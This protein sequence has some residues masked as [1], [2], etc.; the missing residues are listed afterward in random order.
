M[1]MQ[2]SSLS[3]YPAFC[4]IYFARER[5]TAKPTTM[6]FN[7]L[8]NAKE[9]GNED[10]SSS[11]VH[12]FLSS[13]SHLDRVCVCSMYWALRSSYEKVAYACTPAAFGRRASATPMRLSRVTSVCSCAS[14]QFYTQPEKGRDEQCARVQ[15]CQMEAVAKSGSVIDRFKGAA[16][17]LNSPRCPPAA[18]EAPGSGARR[19]YHG[20]LCALRLAVWLKERSKGK[21]D[22]KNNN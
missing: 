22:E 14:L 15:G 17:T 4:R 6:S 7:P 9:A 12:L 20:Q 16:S 11:P 8:A 1:T 19:C 3:L 21:K 2:A 5:R 10:S 18:E 13:L